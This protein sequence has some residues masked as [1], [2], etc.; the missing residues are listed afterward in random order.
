MSFP[1]LTLVSH[2]RRETS[3]LSPQEKFGP[4]RTHPA[5]TRR[6]QAVGCVD[7]WSLSWCY[8]WSSSRVSVQQIPQLQQSR[9]VRPRK[10]PRPVAWGPRQVTRLTS[11]RCGGAYPPVSVRLAVLHVGCR[12]A[13]VILVCGAAALSIR[14]SK[15]SLLSTLRF[16]VMP[17]TA[18]VGRIVNFA[19]RNSFRSSDA[20][21]SSS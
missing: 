21:I 15:F 3:N 18:G 19:R 11:W 16:E 20:Q 4:P 14:V 7:L 2:F 8:R 9:F 17:G 6:P 1:W 12:F 13:V 5:P 10:I